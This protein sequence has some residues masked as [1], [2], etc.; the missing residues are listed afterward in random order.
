MHRGAS[1]KKKKGVA[2]VVELSNMSKGVGEVEVEAASGAVVQPKQ[3]TAY[4][5][6]TLVLLTWDFVECVGEPYK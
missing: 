5:E 3:V 1:E 2:A 4:I 6:V